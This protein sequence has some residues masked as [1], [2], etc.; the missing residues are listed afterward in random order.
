MKKYYVGKELKKMESVKK[1]LGLR[2][3][4]EYF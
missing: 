1:I 3:F 4:Y 2:I